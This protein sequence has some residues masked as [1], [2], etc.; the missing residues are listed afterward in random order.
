MQEESAAT[1]QA[2]A[3]DRAATTAT[4]TPE[5]P[6]SDSAPSLSAVD[7]VT[8]P[9][10]SQALQYTLGPAVVGTTIFWIKVGTLEGSSFQLRSV[11]LT[12]S[13]NAC[14]TGNCAGLRLIWLMH[15]S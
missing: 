10:G 7:S 3:T 4:N 15:N 5:T 14:R 12:L 9:L 1:L 2:R 11:M 6:T 8:S 13:E